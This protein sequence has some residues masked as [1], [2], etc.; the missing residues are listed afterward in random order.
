MFGDLHNQ[1]QNGVMEN[2]TSRIFI[3]LFKKIV[4]GL[5][6]NCRLAT[7]Q[8]IT[9]VLCNDTQYSLTANDQTVSYIDN[10]HEAD[11]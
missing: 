5:G 8:W 11:F 10:S 6:V 7:R 2:N 1:F 3:C 9:N 4:N